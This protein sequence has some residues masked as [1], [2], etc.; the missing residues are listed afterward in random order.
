MQIKAFRQLSVYDIENKLKILTKE[1]LCNNL[2][3]SLAFWT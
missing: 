2:S 3:Q 1:Y